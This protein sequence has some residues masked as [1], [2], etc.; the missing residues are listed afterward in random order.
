MH[1]PHGVTKLKSVAAHSNA[2]EVDLT[3]AT[4]LGNHLHLAPKHIMSLHPEI[5]WAQRSSPSEPEKVRY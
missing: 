5:L 2:L 4:K 1:E 3:S